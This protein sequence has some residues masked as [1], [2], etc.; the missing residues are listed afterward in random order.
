MIM[1]N[2]TDNNI[3]IYFRPLVCPQPGCKQ[4]LG[5]QCQEG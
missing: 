3:H 1:I 2:N 4:N 5:G